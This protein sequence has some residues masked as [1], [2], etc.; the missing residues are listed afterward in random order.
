MVPWRQV[1]IIANLQVGG[2]VTEASFRSRVDDI[3]CLNLG[4]RK[5][6]IIYQS[7][8]KKNPNIFLLYFSRQLCFPVSLY[9]FLRLYQV[10][11]W[12]WSTELLIVMLLKIQISK[13]QCQ[14]LLGLESVGCYKT[15]KV[16]GSFKYL[17]EFA[18]H[19]LRI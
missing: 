19:S 10:S 6:F 1:S 14:S 5:Y 11:T 7:L 3:M 13:G 18:T 17:V 9:F 8:L 16:F 2:G 15:V 12:F 4:H